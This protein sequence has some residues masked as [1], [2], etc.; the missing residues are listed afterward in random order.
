[1]YP[2]SYL[3]LVIAL[4]PSITEIVKTACLAIELWLLE[5]YDIIKPTSR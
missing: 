5:R 1:M 3:S 4:K 2:E